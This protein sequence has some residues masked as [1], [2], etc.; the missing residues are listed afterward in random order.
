MTQYT[1]NNTVKEK[2]VYN[3]LHPGQNKADDS[4]YIDLIELQAIVCNRHK[5]SLHVVKVSH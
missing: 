3:Y 4:P 1:V 2:S 5:P